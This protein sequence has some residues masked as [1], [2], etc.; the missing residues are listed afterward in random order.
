ML[1]IIGFCTLPGYNLCFTL[2][3]FQEI[4][5]GLRIGSVPHDLI[6]CSESESRGGP[7]HRM[8]EEQVGGND[9]YYDGYYFYY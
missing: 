5:Q 1:L 6:P 3:R 9:D 7:V 2:P 4:A 8:F